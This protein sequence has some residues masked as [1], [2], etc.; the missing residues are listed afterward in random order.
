MSTTEKELSVEA[1]GC[2]LGDVDL[3]GRGQGHDDDQK[4][5]KCES[6]LYS[7]EEHLKESA[8]V[9]PVEGN[10]VAVESPKQGTRT[11]QSTSYESSDYSGYSAEERA[12]FAEYDLVCSMAVEVGKLSEW[13]R[14]LREERW[15]EAV[16][17]IKYWSK[18]IKEAYTL[19]K[20]YAEEAGKYAM[21]GDIYLHERY[22]KYTQQKLEYA[23]NFLQVL[24]DWKAVELQFRPEQHTP[25]DN[26]VV[27]LKR[28]SIT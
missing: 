24:Q 3:Q 9:S 10:G 16:E 27:L 5:Q 19:A 13:M 11:C 26:S 25:S 1:L 8:D 23:Q 21:L 6:F 12:C 18:E 22:A 7:A 17:G 28:N 15:L 14:R 20:Q 2:L 4:D